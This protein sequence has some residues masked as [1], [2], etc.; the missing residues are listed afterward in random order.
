M[1][2]KPIQSKM[3]RRL[4]EVGSMENVRK[5]LE[6]LHPSDTAELFSELPPG[7]M[8]RLLD[9]LFS[10]KRAGRVLSEMPEHFLPD[11]LSK[12]EDQ[13]LANVLGNLEP[14]DAL[15]LLE[16]IGDERHKI[17]FELIPGVN[18][19]VLQRML[20]YPP[21]S[22]G[23]IMNVNVITLKEGMTAEQ[24]IEH[25][26]E[27]RE[28]MGI[29]YL[30]V[31]DE[32][33]R[34][35]GI[36]NLRD[37]L[38]AEANHSVKDLMMT[39]VMTVAPTEDKETV[40]QLFAKYDLLG[41]PVVD[42]NRKLLGMITVDDVIDIVKDE[43]T[44]DMYYMAGLSEADRAFSTL[45]ESTRR[46]MPWMTLNLVTAFAT[47]LVIAFFQDSIVKAVSLAIFMPFVAQLAGNVGIQ[48]LTVITRSIALG[49]LE[50]A[51]AWRAI[52]KEISTGLV[53]G[54]SLGLLTGIIGYIWKGD[55]HLGLL[56]FISMA[57][58]MMI[59]GTVGSLIPL[60]LRALRLDPALGSGVIV[61]A[62]TDIS[63]F[64]IFLGLGTSFLKY[65]S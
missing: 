25:L 37:L 47:S 34:L 22:A 24:A 50:W 64:L 49:E 29:Y 52:F 45:P 28:R 62:F 44:E 12:I 8:M 36:L 40:A 60:T 18:R 19:D 26:R 61:I 41:M 38:L 10:M 31:V 55:F 21:D 46:R 11:I 57:L 4:M 9:V 1:P 6:K 3:L 20:L 35:S 63:S 39:Q 42:E 7:E 30:Y 32:E 15:F 33:N 53:I 13:R 59:A 58:A 65:L 54:V 43:A 51:R 27:N 14:D 16:H 23:N 17:L 2:L 5:S 48:T 56:L